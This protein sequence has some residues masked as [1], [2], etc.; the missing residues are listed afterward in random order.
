MCGIAGFWGA[1]QS[2]REPSVLL[3]RMADTL[4]HRGPDDEGVWW[5]ERAEVGLAHRRLS[6]LDLSAEG[7]QPMVSASGRFVIVYNGEVYNFADIRRE[8]AGQFWR[9]HS[10]TEMILEAIERWG[11]ERAVR[12]FIGMFAFALWDRESQCLH[13]V[14][15]RIGIKPLYYGWCGKTFL[16]ASEL[17]AI[18]AHP[19]FQAAVDRDALALLM[20]HNYVP[21]PYCIYAGIRKLQPGTILTVSGANGDAV[22]K[23]FWSARDVAEEGSRSPLTISENDATDKLQELL[24]DAV[25]LRMIADVPVGAFLS[26]GID[27]STVVALMQEQSN[28]RVHTFTIGFGESGFDESIYAREIARHLGTDHTEVRLTPEEAMAVIPQ[29]PEIYD[30]PFSD[31]SQIP[32]FL[33]SRLAR[34]HV[35]VSLS[36]DGGDELFAGYQRYPWTERLWH[37]VDRIPGAIRRACAGALTSLSP[38]AWDRCMNACG[39]LVPSRFRF[40]SLGDKIHKFSALFSTDRPEVL[41]AYA[42]SHWTDCL[43]LGACEPPTVLSDPMQ[44]AEVTTLLESMMY[45]DLTSYLP[46]D[47]LTKVDRASMAVGLEARVPLLDHR[48]VEFAWR[49]P[50]HM[51][52]RNGKSKWLLRQVLG[53]YVPLSLVDR[54]KMGFG[55]PL[56]EWLRGPLREW[57]EDL[58]SEDRLHRDGYFDPRMVRS[59]WGEHLSGHRNWHY[60]LWDVLMFQAW[61]D[62]SGGKSWPV[63]EMPL[64]LRG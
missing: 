44:A 23:T 49:L 59:K 48:V 41:Y 1:S 58:I 32:T 24:S 29:L 28:S 56:G 61:L 45:M 60:W 62:R 37:S 3:T 9:G 7:H 18:R 35:T 27:S 31:S 57:A 39:A 40:A 34:A 30:E 4:A 38:S 54:P 8:L 12:R 19:D 47:I 42:V 14:R 36:G 63:C 33:V 26:G 20:R 16:F 25:R 64:A 52:I 6:I 21:A 53:R 11:L 50:L 43:V 5:D 46:D 51:K 22:P 2:C 55:V 10:D 17:K 15:D 13:L